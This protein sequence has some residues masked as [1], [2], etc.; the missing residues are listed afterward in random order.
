MEPCGSA[1]QIA[2]AADAVNENLMRVRIQQVSRLAA[3]P[4]MPVA[5]KTPLLAAKPVADRLGFRRINN[6][7]RRTTWLWAGLVWLSWT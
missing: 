2:R 7:R 3:K 1:I 4:A 5:A 6:M